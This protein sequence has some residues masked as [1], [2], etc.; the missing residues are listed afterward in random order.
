MH[1]RSRKRIE[2]VRNV[3]ALHTVDAEIDVTKKI[4]LLAYG[5]EQL[6]KMETT[7]RLQ[8]ADPSKSHQQHSG[9][10]PRSF[11]S[12]GTTGVHF[13]CYLPFISTIQLLL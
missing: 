3:R 12:K 10:D 4:E 7:V 5:N 6:N 2:N 8:R 13:R 9:I 1:E 11:Q